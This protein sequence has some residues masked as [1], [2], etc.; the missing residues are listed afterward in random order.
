MV[1]EAGRVSNDPRNGAMRP[2]WFAL[3]EG[4]AAF[5]E[6]LALQA[7]SRDLA[8]QQQARLRAASD[9]E[10]LRWSIQW[11]GDFCYPELRRRGLPVPGEVTS[12]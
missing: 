5:R 11:G 6:E 1:K 2:L 9:A 4:W 12:A 8:A 3:R 10:L 7:A